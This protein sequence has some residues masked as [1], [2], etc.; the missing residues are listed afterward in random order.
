M[1]SQR[2]AVAGG[3]GKLGLHLVEGLLE[4]KQQHSLEIIVLSRSQAPDISYAGSS[5][6][7]IAVDY[8]DQES[9]RKVLND[10]QIDTI[11]S[12]ICGFDSDAFIASQENLLRAGLS[13]PSYRRFAPS[14]FAV[15]SEQVPGVKLYQMKVPILHL[16]QQTKRERPDSFEY[17]RFNCGIFMNYLG[18]GNTK[19]EAHKA[20][21]HLAHFPYIFDLSKHTA[22]VPS[23]GDIQLVYTCV[24]D[25]GKFVAAATQLD[26][27]EEFNDMAG[28]VLTMNEVIRMCE[29]VSGKFACSFWVIKRPKQIFRGEIR[30]QIQHE[31]GYFRTTGSFSQE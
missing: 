21:G 13:I 9:I 6:P 14:E 29:S 30:G 16:L 27:W 26:E 25:V 28:E 24:E 4:I 15:D 19:S 20:H 11:I 1:K 5:A 2:I 23:D 10:H 3:A 17:S 18:Y 8:Q 12:T 31:R 22:D 7:V